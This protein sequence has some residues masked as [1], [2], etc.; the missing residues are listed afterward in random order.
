MLNSNDSMF[1]PLFWLFSFSM[2]SRIS[3]VPLEIQNLLIP[4]SRNTLSQY[5]RVIFSTSC[6][7]GVSF[8]EACFVTDFFD[9][10][11]YRNFTGF[12]CILIEIFMIGKALFSS[13]TFSLGSSQGLQRLCN[14]P[15]SW[16]IF[17]ARN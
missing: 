6:N 8:L 17:F 2:S 3:S 12:L 15:Y 14:R 7:I 9:A 10:I 1:L 11:M 13:A 16:N 4:V 5:H